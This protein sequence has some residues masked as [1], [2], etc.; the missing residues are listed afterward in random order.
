MEVLI[1]ISPHRSGRWKT[2]AS[3]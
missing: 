2:P 3:S 1:D